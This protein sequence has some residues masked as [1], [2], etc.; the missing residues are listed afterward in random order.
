MTKKLLI[1]ADLGHLKVFRLEENGE[2]GRPRAILLEQKSTEVTNHLT[3]VVTDRAGQYR[4]G[5]AGAGA[6]NM[7]D[8]EEHNLPLERRRRA[9]KRLA[10]HISSLIRAEKIESWYL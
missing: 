1:V 7:S 3:E 5:V 6:S 4:K 9:L 10:Q 2:S 8:G